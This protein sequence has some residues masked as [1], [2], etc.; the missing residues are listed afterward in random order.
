MGVIGMI[1]ADPEAPCPTPCRKKYRQRHPETTVLHCIIQEHLEGFLLHA[2]ESFGKRLPKYVENE[3]RRYLE[4]GLHA[5]GFARAVYEI[6]GDELLLPFS[7]K[8]RG[9]CPSSGSKLRRWDSSEPNA[10]RSRSVNAL[11]RASI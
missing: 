3:F 5:Q 1:V 9:L 11:E 7:C 6:C 8:L 2:Q 4:C 10:L